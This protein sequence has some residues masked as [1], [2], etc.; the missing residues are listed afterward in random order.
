VS[1][2]NTGLTTLYN[3]SGA[4]QSLVVTIAPPAG[5][6]SGFVSAPTGQVFN[7]TSGFKVTSNGKTGKASFIFDTE[8]G[9]ISGW[10]PSV[11]AGSSVLAVDNSQKGAVY[12]GL[13]LGTVGGNSFLYATNFESGEVE[14]YNSSFQLAGQFTDPT[15]AAG[16]APFN[17]AVLDGKLYVTFAL[18]DAAKHDDVAG[19]GNG[20][21]DV[22]NLDGSFDTR[23]ISGGVLDSPWG[24]DIAPTGFGK[25][26][27]DL[28]V[29]NFGNGE[30][31]AFNPTTGQFLGTLL[32][33]NGQPIV[34]G[35]LWG[36]I[37]GNGGAGGNLN[38]VYFSSGVA[39]EAGGLFGS[40]SVPEPSTWAMMILGVAAVG[41]CARRRPRPASSSFA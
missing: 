33:S 18:Q 39:D 37:N 23:L 27:D 6:P 28:L 34:E 19:L 13:A 24:L 36:L 9:T 40:L 41:I 22:F 4:P 14:M 1:D 30:I 17:A 16:Y 2:N 15:V 25:Y 32:G 8:D 3:T 35:S 26:A 31:N 20:Y 29:G 10:S 12:K 5:S 11:N 7:S 38:S 21:V